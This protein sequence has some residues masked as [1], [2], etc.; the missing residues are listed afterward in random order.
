MCDLKKIVQLLLFLHF[1]NFL[2]LLQLVNVISNQSDYAFKFQDANRSTGLLLAD[3]DT[4]IYCQYHSAKL[5]NALQCQS[6]KEPKHRPSTTNFH[7]C[8]FLNSQ[9]FT[10]F[11]PV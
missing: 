3:P 2:I 7:E 10:H 9:I 1:V 11:K 5:R 4:T 6:K 8:D